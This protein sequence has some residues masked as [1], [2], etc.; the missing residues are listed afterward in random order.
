[1][2][3]RW[4]RGKSPE[5]VWKPGLIQWFQAIHRGVISLLWYYAPRVEADAKENAPWMDRTTNARQGLNAFVDESDGSIR[6]VLKHQ[7]SY[8]PY[9]ELSNG[10]KYAIILPTLEAHYNEIWKSVKE[11]LS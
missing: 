6:L 5:Q 4:V 1:M 2:T 11:L 9:L 3:F 10:A 7:V 8:G